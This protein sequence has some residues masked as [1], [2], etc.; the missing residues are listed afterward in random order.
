MRSP[1]I[2]CILN[3]RLLIILYFT[4][5]F[6]ALYKIFQTA[7]PKSGAGITGHTQIPSRRYRHRTNFRSI[8]QTGTLKLL[9][10]ETAAECLQPFQ[11][12]FIFIFAGKRLLRHTVDLVRCKPESQHIV[13]I[14][15]VKFIRA[16]QIFR[17][18][19][20]D[21]VLWRQKFRAD[22]SVQNIQKH[23]RQFNV[24]AGIRIITNQVSHQRFRHGCVYSVHGHMISAV[25]RPAQCQL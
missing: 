18:L 14:K 12:N 7:H 6:H 3:I 20:N 2:P 24:P 19:G 11:N 22:R 5:F 16:N 8:R 4:R 25:R 1:F 15:I 13:Q 9:R 23:R 21:S 10:K 17:L